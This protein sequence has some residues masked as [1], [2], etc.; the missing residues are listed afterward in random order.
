MSSDAD[1]GAVAAGKGARRG[2]RILGGRRVRPVSPSTWLDTS[3]PPW[4]AYDRK[5]VAVLVVLLVLTMRLAVPVG[6]SGTSVALPLTYALIGL[7]WLRRRLVIDGLRVELLGV[8]IAAC[9][10]TTAAVALQ[11]QP[12]SQPSLLLLLVIYLPWVLR[13]GGD[14]GRELVEHAGRV[15]VR[16]MLVVAAAGTAQFAGQLAGAWQYE[17]YLAD[18]LPPGLLIAGY[19]TSIPVMFGS[20][21]YKSNGFVLLEP[22]FLS[23]YCALAVI[24]GL[25]L[26]I[27][28]WQVLL[29]LSGLVSAVSGTGLVLLA[30]GLVL[31]LVRARRRI[32]P[33]HV[34]AAGLAA[35][36]LFLSP[37][38]TLL[39]DRSDEVSQQ[40]SSGNARF[41]QPYL[42]AAAGLEA[43][44]QRYAVGA[45][46]GSAE[47]LLE[48]ARDG[49]GYPVLYSPLPKLVFEYGLVAGGL[50]LMFILL[51]MFDG[52]PWP[53]VPATLIVMTLF[54]SGGLLQAQTAYLAWLLT[55][56]GATPRPLAKTPVLRWDPG[57]ARRTVVESPPS[58][59]LPAGEHH[60]DDG[61]DGPSSETQRG[62][63]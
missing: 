63:P 6:P 15:F 61:P 52:A 47:R 19:N 50:F 24:V 46:P 17:D 3:L 13:V 8:A 18:I 12:F 36:L 4:E 27:R 11:T 22:S 23:Q 58:L 35:A 37:A 48:S 30:V 16:V 26:G 43:D 32:R 42:E 5:I 56:F 55:G 1:H 28:A 45:G 2:P 34:V 60:R 31:I 14:A 38:A 7:L 25:M 51:S 53:V 33:G 54:L 41:L 59:T 29:L 21:M 39:L 40:G 9:L 49:I 10:I 57:A 62:D 44:H 20:S